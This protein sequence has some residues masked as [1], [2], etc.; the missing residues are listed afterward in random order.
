VLGDP[1]GASAAEGERL[2]DLLVADL[3][4]TVGRLAEAAG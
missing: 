2:L 1:A 3:A 4:A